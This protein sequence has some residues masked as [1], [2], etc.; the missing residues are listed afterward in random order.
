MRRA[1]FRSW[2]CARWMRSF[3]RVA[4]TRVIWGNYG[5]TSLKLTA[6]FALLAALAL[7]ACFG[8]AQAD[9]ASKL[10]VRA[11]RTRGHFPNDDSAL[12]LLFLG[13][14]LAERE[15]SMARA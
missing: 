15:W 2:R 1:V 3:P 6:R 10:P 4:T 9:A 12:K 13:L 7:P 11:V 14:N 5:G 8:A